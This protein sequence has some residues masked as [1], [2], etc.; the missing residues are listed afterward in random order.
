MESFRQWICDIAIYMIVVTL[1]YRLSAN[2][3]YKPY[4]KLITG[5]LMIVLIA[6]P[7]VSFGNQD[8]QEYLERETTYYQ[9]ESARMS[10]N[11]YEEKSKEIILASYKEEITAQLKEKV[12][13]YGLFLQTVDME[14]GEGEEYGVLKEVSL[15]ASYDKNPDTILGEITIEDSVASVPEIKM[16]QWIS[17]NFG[18]DEDDINISIKK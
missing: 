4:I 7:V 12:E 2:S 6:K 3:S 13:E 15:T 1:I 11:I 5:L 10:K 9:I 8:F 17:E 18:V 16:T 14:F